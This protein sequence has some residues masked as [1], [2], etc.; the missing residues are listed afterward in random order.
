MGIDKRE[1]RTAPAEAAK[2]V[3]I[4][5]QP[6]SA[7]D[8][9]RQLAADIDAGKYGNIVLVAGVLADDAGNIGP[10]SC[11]VPVSRGELVGTL[12]MAAVRLAIS[13]GS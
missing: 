2:V 11:G 1:L 12:N 10:F 13:G 8:Q 5:P 9:V 4:T 6:T 7:A 3:P